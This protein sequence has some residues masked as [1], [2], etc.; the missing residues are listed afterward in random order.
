MDDLEQLKK[1]VDEVNNLVE[2]LINRQGEIVERLARLH[3]AVIFL[4]ES[5]G[6]GSEGFF[7]EQKEYKH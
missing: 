6:E 5:V 2:G 7:E 3:G 4:L 1:D